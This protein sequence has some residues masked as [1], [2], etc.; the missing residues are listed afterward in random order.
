MYELETSEMDYEVILAK[1]GKENTRDDSCAEAGF[2]DNS[3]NM[4]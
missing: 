1:N 4:V 2:S 3:L